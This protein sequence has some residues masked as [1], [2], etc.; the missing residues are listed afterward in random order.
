[1][2]VWLYACLWRIDVKASECPGNWQ[3]CSNADLGEA[4]D[5]GEKTLRRNAQEAHGC[6]YEIYLTFTWTEV[7]GK[8]RHPEMLARTCEGDGAGGARLARDR[9]Q[10]ADHVPR[11]EPRY[12]HG[13]L[14][15]AQGTLDEKVHARRRRALF[16]YHGAS[17]QLDVLAPKQQRLA[18]LSK[19]TWQTQSAHRLTAKKF[20][21]YVCEC[22]VRARQ[23]NSGTNRSGK[24][25]EEAGR[26]SVGLQ[27]QNLCDE[28]AAMGRIGQP[29]LLRPIRK[30]FIALTAGRAQRRLDA[31]ALH[32]DGSVA[33]QY[34][35]KKHPL[36]RSLR[37]PLKLWA[38][39]RSAH[40][41][42][43]SDKACCGF[44]CPLFQPPSLA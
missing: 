36:S 25:G 18:R 6:Q 40:A 7:H 19:I 31:G 3:S 42:V 29:R 33:Y 15:N 16:Q 10:L 5:D 23:V 30:K 37:A 22:L 44:L 13:T 43:K 17:G 21:I 32:S 28:R 24:C 34:L 39:P 2:R 8:T 9:S 41:A 14:C 4:V 20:Y 1:V 27:T 35:Y 11:L 26:G 38:C 12:F